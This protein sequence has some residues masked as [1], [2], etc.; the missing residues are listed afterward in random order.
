MTWSQIEEKPSMDKAGIFFQGEREWIQCHADW[1]LGNY[2]WV[3]SN[4]IFIDVSSKYSQYLHSLFTVVFP[5]EHREWCF[6]LLIDQQAQHGTLGTTGHQWDQTL[7]CCSCM[8]GL[9][10]F[11]STS[12]TEK[13][14]DFKL[15]VTW[16][17]E[18]ELK[19]LSFYFIFKERLH[20]RGKE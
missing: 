18:E 16:R 2:H 5:F 3:F 14:W 11:L 7:L 8:A 19:C 15:Q 12:T 13:A 6:F 17:G 1:S 20:V 4:L 10:E 9:S